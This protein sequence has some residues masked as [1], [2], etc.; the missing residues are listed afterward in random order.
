MPPRPGGTR[1]VGRT[2]LAAIT[3]MQDGEQ[4][5]EGILEREK[6]RE[7]SR[8]A[9]IKA[10][11]SRSGGG[12]ITKLG[13]YDPDLYTLGWGFVRV[14]FIYKNTIYPT[15]LRTGLFWWLLF[16]HAFLHV[17]ESLMHWGYWPGS[18]EFSAAAGGSSSRGDGVGAAEIDVD[19]GGAEVDT[20]VR[21]HLSTTAPYTWGPTYS[22]APGFNGLPRIDWKVATVASSLMIFFLVFYTVNEYQRYNTFFAN[23][24]GIAGD[25]QEWLALCKMHLPRGGI[26]SHGQWNAARLVLAGQEIM[27]YSCHGEGVDDEEWDAMVERGLLGD[28]E[29][30]QLRSYKGNQSWLCLAWALEEA[31]AQIRRETAR[32]AKTSRCPAS[33]DGSDP[34][35]PSEHEMLAEY[36]AMHETIQHFRDEA[37]D[38]RMHCGQIANWRRMQVPFPYFHLLNLLVLFNLV[39]ISYAAVPLTCWPLSLL[40]VF[41]ATFTILGMRCVAIALSDPFGHDLTDF[42]LEPFMK[43]AYEEAVA[44]LQMPRRQ[45]LHGHLPPLASGKALFDPVHNTREAWLEAVEMKDS[46]AKGFG[47]HF[48][49]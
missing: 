44:Q 17:I 30:T 47:V 39:M 31:E 43:N 42:A 26:A 23:T 18:A 25:I 13:R 8:R 33:A 2:A 19:V 45:A 21:R 5:A 9:S 16:L 49:V 29:I 46:E 22:T 37:E 34:A 48:E 40:A 32:R 1:G 4:S 38:I 12:A 6:R 14:L 36:I 15:V 24:V 27:Y 11:H 10:K 35:P 28:G 3:A 7:E 20:D 41:A